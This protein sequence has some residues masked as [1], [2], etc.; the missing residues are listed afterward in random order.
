M[1]KLASMLMMLVA[2]SVLA[3]QNQLSSPAAES[4]SLLEQA[5]SDKNPDVRRQAAQAMSLLNA[6][7]PL[8]SELGAMVSDRDVSVRVAAVSA[9]G[10]FKSRRNIPLLRQAL[11][12]PVPEVGISAAKALYDLHQPEGQEYLLAV[13]SGQTKAASSYITSQARSTVRLLHTPTKLF[14]TAAIGA[15][16][17]AVPLPGFAFGLASV[18]GILSDPGASARAA[19]LLLLGNS[20]DPAVAE[21][22]RSAL[23]DKEWSVRAAA[24][25]VTAM[26]PYPQFREDLVPLLADK[27]DAV[28]LRAAAAYLRLRSIEIR[29]RGRRRRS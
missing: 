27:K 24:V 1:R 19:A 23:L 2:A 5:A 20:R 25:H 22:V 4:R 13:V 7:N 9:L 14:T 3:A 29:R 26:H 11:S 18:E 15:A 16:G 10:D 12:D 8:L 21:A 17:M 6:T 28:R